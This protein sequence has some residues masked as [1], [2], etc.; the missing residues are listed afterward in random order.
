M[1]HFMSRD[2]SIIVRTLLVF[3]HDIF[4]AHFSNKI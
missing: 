1:A 2:V 4:Q 3:I